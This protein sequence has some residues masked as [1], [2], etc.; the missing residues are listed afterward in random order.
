[1]TQKQLILNYMIDFGSITPMQAFMD[2]GCT[3]LAT[4]IGELIKYGIPIIKTTVKSKNR[5][6]KKCV[7]KRYSLGDRYVRH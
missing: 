4:R 7:Y 3:K 1:M 6:G 2:L 5:Y